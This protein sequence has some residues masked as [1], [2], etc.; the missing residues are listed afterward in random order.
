M[1]DENVSKG[2][3][4]SRRISD[5]MFDVS[6]WNVVDRQTLQGGQQMMI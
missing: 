6:T 2:E 3:S 1:E 4:R 5:G